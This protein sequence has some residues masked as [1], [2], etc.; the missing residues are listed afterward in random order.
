MSSPSIYY[1]VEFKSR[2]CDKW[3][4][5]MQFSDEESAK[6]AMKGVRQTRPNAVMRIRKIK[7]NGDV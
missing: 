2:M 4:Y 3:N 1:R 6:K 7:G 5:F